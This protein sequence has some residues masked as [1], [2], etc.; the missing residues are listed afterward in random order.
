M[1]IKDS[2]EYSK[3]RFMPFSSI[4]YN[5]S[6]SKY[7]GSHFNSGSTLTYT[8]S[9]TGDGGIH[10]AYVGFGWN[11]VADLSIGANFGYIWGNYEQSIAQNGYQIIPSRLSARMAVTLMRP[12]AIVLKSVV[13]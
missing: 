1:P 12:T 5:F 7:L 6:E 8:N 11:P 4:G 9:Y 13:K 10:Q 3:R 2:G